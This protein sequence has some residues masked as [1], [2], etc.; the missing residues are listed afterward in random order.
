M[1]NT[2]YFVSRVGQAIFTFMC[3]LTLTFSLIRLMPG[4]PAALIK[5]R[6]EQSG[7]T[8]TEEEI[9][10]RVE[11]LTKVNPDKPIPQAYA[12]YVSSV[13]TGDLGQSIW[14]SR[15]VMEI[16]ADA[17]PWTIY[18]S[19]VSLLLTYAIGIALGAAMAYSEGSRFDFS[20]TSVSIVIT[21]IP[22]YV[23]AIALL[24][25]LGYEGG[26]FP[27]GGR[28]AQ[29]IEPGLSVAYVGSILHHSILPIAA[30][31]IAGFGG[32]ALSMRGNSI[33]ILGNDYLR[34]ARLRGLSE[35]RISMRYVARNAI[36]PMYTGIM[37]SIGSLF[38]GSII[39]EQIFTYPGAGYYVFKSLGARDY[40]LLMG[41]FLFITLGVV[42]GVFVADLTYG[43]V[44]PRAG[45]G[46]D[47][48]SF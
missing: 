41:G 46:A 32:K 27:T 6:L 17:M 39:L 31:T 1:A 40:P 20:S 26:F 8:F 2:K 25:F 22:F 21:S 23:V 3:V 13:L 19:A 47:R 18:L 12:D 44:D 14:Y 28:V 10:N 24:W 36:L 42:F 30:L 35:R 48:E 43:L 16:L 5:A 29:D 9:N 7:R 38:G 45:S 37:I 34:V 33:Q 15:T 4:G 11:L